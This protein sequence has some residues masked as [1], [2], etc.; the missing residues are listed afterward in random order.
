LAV[1]A[2][3]PPLWLMLGV[4]TI[5]AF[6]LW[7][8]LDPYNSLVADLFPARQR[9]RVGGILGLAQMLG[10][11]MFLLFAIN[12]W[13]STR[14]SVGGVTIPI[15][16]ELVVFGVTITVLLL[17][18]SFTFLT[19]KE[20][21]AAPREAQLERASRPNPILYLVDLLKY[22]EAARYTLALTFFWIG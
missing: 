8:A 21:V 5:A 11:I 15:N 20:P 13:S 12:L 22:Q 2:T 10:S 4:L 14:I 17:T 1:L 18:F 3:H 7:V 16:G 6:F 19:V 9:G